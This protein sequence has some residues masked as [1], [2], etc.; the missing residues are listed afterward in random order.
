MLPSTSGSAERL[1]KRRRFRSTSGKRDDRK[2]KHRSPNCTSRKHHTR[3]HHSQDR[4]RHAR[5]R[6]SQ[7]H[8]IIQIHRVSLKPLLTLPSHNMIQKKVIFLTALILITNN[9][10]L[11]SSH[12]DPKQQIL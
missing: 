2:R 1:Q 10:H 12:L 5:R 4:R 9:S 3:L 8:Q 6:I 7:A 11:Q